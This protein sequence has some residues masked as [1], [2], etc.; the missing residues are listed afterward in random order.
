MSSNTCAV[1]G[2]IS[3]GYTGRC[4]SDSCVE[5]ATRKDERDQIVSDIRKLDGDDR[6]LW[7]Y[8]MVAM[9]IE[10]RAYLPHG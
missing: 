8:E 5:S 4:D 6:E 9:Y 2:Y 1:C 3:H 10:N 7:A